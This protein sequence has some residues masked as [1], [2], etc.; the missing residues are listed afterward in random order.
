M[1][2]NTHS[3]PYYFLFFI[4]FLFPSCRVCF[5]FFF[6]FFNGFWP[7]RVQVGKQVFEGCVRDAL[8]GKTR[9][10]VTNQL[11][12]LPQVRTGLPCVC[13]PSTHLGG[14]FFALRWVGWFLDGMCEGSM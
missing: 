12:F 9:V 11:Q 3:V 4:F 2:L 1:L 5:F 14:V 7:W 13:T 6:F 8:R 10:L